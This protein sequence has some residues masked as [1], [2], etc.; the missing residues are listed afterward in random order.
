MHAGS[1]LSRNGQLGVQWTWP[2]TQPT[3][4]QAAAPRALGIQGGRRGERLGPAEIVG[5]AQG[6]ATRTQREASLYAKAAEL[7]L[8]GP[9]G[10]RKADLWEGELDGEG[11][12]QGAALVDALREGVRARLMRHADL[13]RM[14][15]AMEWF[16]DFTRDTTRVPFVPL[17]HAGDLAAGAYNAETM[18][19]M[20]EYMRLRGSRKAGKLGQPLQS[21]HV[22]AC[23]STIRMLRSAEAHY[24]VVVPATDTNL[25]NLYKEMRKDN[26]P[27]GERKECRGFRMMHFR[28]LIAAG[29]PTQEGQAGTEWA[30]ALLAHNV[31]LRGGEVGRTDSKPF[32]ASRD[33]TLTSVVLMPPCEESGWLP[34]LIVWVVSIKD[35]AVRF[36][37]VPLPV[38]A[39]EDGGDRACTYTAV[40]A[41]LRRRQREVPQC[42]RACP[43]C[44][45]AE[46]AA[47]KGGA[48]PE[49][50]ARANAPLFLTESGTE[51]TTQHV[52][53]VGKRMAV[54]AGMPSDAVGGK[55]WRIGGATDAREI[56]GDASRDIIK[57]RGRWGSDVS[58][59][60]QRAL[61]R[62][63]LG[64]SAALARAH[65]RDME[66][67]VR[68]W[69]QPATFR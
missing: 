4:R 8:C 38:R 64:A 41:Q 34:W 14:G 65:T 7:G 55:L 32:D 36:R 60:Y 42:V 67:M 33:L 58:G 61:T 26:G 11:N 59:V 50:C 44:K 52:R 15:T 39:L 12:G 6:E 40:V 1:G 21:D 35:P 62:D 37:A 17:D 16:A 18:E 45:P 2:S 25:S 48:P 22:Q 19:L 24:G 47:R 23:V 69:V 54:A 13:G 27:K 30:L 3:A 53:E 28:A 66:Q 31:M 63:M 49:T 29:Y 46:G 9:L 43:W 51:Y 56:L 10:K 20:Q 68:G 5:R 57:Q